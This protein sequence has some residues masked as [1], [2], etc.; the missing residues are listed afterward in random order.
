MKK[1]KEF[2]DNIDTALMDDNKISQFER[3]Y[4]M[5][6]E[7]NKVM[8]LTAITDRN[9]VILKH[10][11]DSVALLKYHKL[12][13]ERM[14]DVGT[15]A[16]FPGI[17]LK[18]ICPGLKVTLFDSLNKRVGFLNEVIEELGL[19]GIEAVHGRAE[20][21]GRDKNLREAY[22][23][24]VSRAV[25]N[26]AVLSE[27]CLPFV[28]IGGWFIPYKS[29]DIEQELADGKKAVSVLGGK[30]DRVEKLEI[31]GNGRSFIF[32]KKERSTPKAYPR[33]AGTA[34]RQPIN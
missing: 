32:I 33:K 19:K 26:M 23:I 3:Y 7:K 31:E 11:I 10:F 20:E 21:G 1:L 24:A 27:Y 17:P 15:G 14:I 2:L 8:N 9:E 13:D 5:L 22:D 4:E 18:I 30:I 16:G 25:A 12:S 29:Y 28:K 34:K 6:I